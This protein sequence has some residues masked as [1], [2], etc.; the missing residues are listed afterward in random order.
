M[1]SLFGAPVDVSARYVRMLAVLGTQ[2][3]HGFVFTDEIVVK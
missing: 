2:P 3:Q 1:Y